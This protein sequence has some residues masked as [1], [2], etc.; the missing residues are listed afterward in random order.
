LLMA[1]TCLLP[2]VH[3]IECVLARNATVFTDRR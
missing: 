3:R 2:Q 1:T